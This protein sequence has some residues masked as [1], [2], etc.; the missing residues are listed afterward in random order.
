MDHP[1]SEQLLAALLKLDRP[2]VVCCP[3]IDDERLARFSN[4]PRA[5]LARPTRCARGP[6]PTRAWS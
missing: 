5:H 4:A 6:R 1:H 2:A 3:D